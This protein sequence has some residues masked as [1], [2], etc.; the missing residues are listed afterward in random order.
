M[1]RMFVFLLVL[2]MIIATSSVIFAKGNSKPKNDN[3]V[4]FDKGFSP[5]QKAA[6]LEIANAIRSGE[7]KTISKYTKNKEDAKNVRT[8]WSSVD[9][10][11]NLKFRAKIY[12]KGFTIYDAGTM[13]YSCDVK[14]DRNSFIIIFENEGCIV[15]DGN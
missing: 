1:K 5:Q 7:V 10:L 4:T 12:K 8:F 15:N 6:V 14:K 2:M 13:M 9:E 3:I 11:S